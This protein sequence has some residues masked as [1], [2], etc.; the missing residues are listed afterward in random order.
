[1]DYGIQLG[2]RFRSLKL[3]FVIRYFGAE[4]LRDRLR[5]HLFL[6]NYFK[7]KVDSHPDFERTAPVPMSTVCFRLHPDKIKDEKELENLNQEFFK[8]LESS[9]DILVSHTRLNGMYVMRVNFSGLRMELKH[10]EESWQIIKSKAE[11]VL[12]NFN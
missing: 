2:R 4:G 8:A 7:D 11:E 6:G 9:K 1:M 12:K 10:V 3:W 5:Y